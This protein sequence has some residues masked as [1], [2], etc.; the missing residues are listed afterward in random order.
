M[1][2]GPAKAPS[3]VTWG[4]VLPYV[5]ASSVPCH[6]STGA[7]GRQRRLPTGGAAYRI[8]R[9]MLTPFFTKPRTWPSAVLTTGPSL[10][11]PS[12]AAV[13]PV[14][15]TTVRSAQ[16]AKLLPPGQESLLKRTPP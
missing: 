2:L 4:Q 16:A 5:V 14:A 15:S 12:W 3:S 8:P 7:G 9:K 6:L 10:S 13:G 1:L 11:R